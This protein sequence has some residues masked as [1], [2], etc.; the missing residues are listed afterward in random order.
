MHLCVLFK[1]TIHNSSP[2]YGVYH[3]GARYGTP[4]PYTLL[5]GELQSRQRLMVF[6]ITKKSTTTTTTKPN[7]RIG[8]NNTRSLRFRSFRSVFMFGG[9][10]AKQTNPA[11]MCLIER[12]PSS[13]GGSGAGANTIS[14]TTPGPT[15]R[16]LC[17]AC[18]RAIH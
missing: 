9:R 2:I 3:F 15:A 7:T 11:H 10:A 16:Q 18:T 6:L 17:L 1:P 5:D 14:T 4:L 13:G 12:I 8:M